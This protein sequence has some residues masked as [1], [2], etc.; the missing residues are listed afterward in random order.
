M[1]EVEI[2]TVD[3]AV[4]E[5]GKHVKDAGRRQGFEPWEH[6]AVCEYADIVGVGVECSD[7]SA[8]C[9]FYPVHERAPWLVRGK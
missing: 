8:E 3:I 5:I 2:P 4:L 9:G 7:E 6:A 1:P